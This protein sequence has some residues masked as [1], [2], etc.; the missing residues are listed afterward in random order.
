MG[1]E[2]AARSPFLFFCD[3]GPELR[4]AVT[5]GR[6]REFARFARF[7]DAETQ[8]EIPDPNAKT[9]FLI[10]KIDWNSLQEEAHAGW[11]AYYRR[12]LTLRTAFI[13]PRLAGMEGRSGRFEL[14]PPGV[15]DVNWLLGDRSTLRLVANFSAQTVRRA[16][17][18]CQ[19]E[20]VFASSGEAT[21]RLLAP[22][23]VTWTL[24]APVPLPES[25]LPAPD[26]G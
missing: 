5:Q 2:F 23:D 18:A 10:S 7:A 3:F 26:R 17:P 22:W 24:Q 12:L 14:F 19:T 13:V 16:M 21:T 9:T 11:L 4:H 1:E 8:A 15:L 6:R 20:T 25:T